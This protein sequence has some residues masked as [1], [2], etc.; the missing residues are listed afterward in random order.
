MI[1]VDTNVMV[2]MLTGDDL[3]QQEAA[4][5]FLAG[6][7]C[8][9]QSTVILEIEWILR[10]VHRYLP[11][12]IVEAFSVLLRTD[13]LDVEQPERLE[14]A[15]AGMRNG[16]DFADAFHIAGAQEAAAFATFDKDLAKRAGATFPKPP[17]VR[18]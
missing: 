8:F 18:P 13:R 2:R 5:A 15:L 7:D 17:V 16:L 10:S 6:N 3:A 4:V 1:A 11:G 12:Q 9:V 14:L